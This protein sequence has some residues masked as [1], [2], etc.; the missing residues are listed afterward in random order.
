MGGFMLIL[1][2][3]NVDLIAYETQ[4]TSPALHVKN[5]AGEIY[6]VPV[7]AMGGGIY[8]ASETLVYEEAEINQCQSVKLG[9]GIYRV[10]MRGGMGGKPYR[11]SAGSGK[12][13]FHGDI[14]S[15]IFKVNTETTVYA[16]RGG[17]GNDSPAV[18]TYQTVG[19]GASGVDSILVVGDRVIRANGA[20]GTQ[21]I[22]G[23][24]SLYTGGH[25]IM[26]SCFGGG[27]G[28]Y[29][30]TNINNGKNG[31]VEGLVGCGGGGG[32][33]NVAGGG[34][35]GKG[36]SN[37]KVTG[38]AGTNATATGGGNGGDAENMQQTS[39]TK[40]YAI[41]GYGGVNVSLECGGAVAV[42]YGGGGGGA[43]CALAD[44]I[45]CAL[46]G[47]RC[48]ADCA[49]GG[50]GGAGSTGTSDSSY[51]KIYKIG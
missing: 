49:D 34:V 5:A 14:V 7:I 50:D 10:E 31:V 18:S 35:A 2:V 29:S 17:D 42:S 37:V 24:V 40:N 8:D 9:A 39:M 16:L 22:N 21:C 25:A 1:H 15:Q 6:H 43:V 45:Q 30:D 26:N 3:G 41:G 46:T 33:A 19:G 48:N 51:I 36:A 4:L 11:C 27:G 47:A 12:V 32:G 28:F 23:G 44:P 13:Q 20:P 38:F